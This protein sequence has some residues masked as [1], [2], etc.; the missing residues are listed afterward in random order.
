[1][2]DVSELLT[3]QQKIKAGK[4]KEEKFNK[5]KQEVLNTQEDEIL[6]LEIFT[7]PVKG[8]SVKVIKPQFNLTF[9][10]LYCI[11][12]ATKDFEKDEPIVEY[13]GILLNH[14]EGKAKEAEYNKANEQGA[15]IGSYM[16]R[17]QTPN[18]WKW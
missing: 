18:G 17:F 4:E 11:F 7:D 16:Y 1:M 9:H 3:R 2:G 10:S 12:Q 14:Q 13:V 5:K 6:G 15:S 8:R